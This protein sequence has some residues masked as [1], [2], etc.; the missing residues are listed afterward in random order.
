MNK[1]KTHRHT[2][3]QIGR[4]YCFGGSVAQHPYTDENRAAH[5][6]V[7]WT[8]ACSICGAERAVNG[9]QGFREYSPWGPTAAERER[10]EREHQARERTRLAAIAA[11]TA[12]AREA[13]AYLVALART[14]AGQ[15]T[16]KQAGYA[17]ILDAPD[18]GDDASTI[19]VARA[20]AL[21]G[22]AR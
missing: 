10:L 22:G 9:N 3:I 14:H 4:E 11:G 21:R 6:N 12:S 8:E 18:R 17:D 13:R 15:H 1:P 20:V 5:G 2:P 16:I 7:T 19:L